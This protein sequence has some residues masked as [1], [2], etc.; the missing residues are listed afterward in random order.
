MHPES[1]RQRKSDWQR[2]SNW[3][4]GV[5]SSSR[6]PQPSW[7][8]DGGTHA[9]AT[10]SN[11]NYLCNV[12]SAHCSAQPWLQSATCSWGQS[13]LAYWQAQAPM[14][15][16]SCAG[17]PS[18]TAAA[19]CAEQQCQVLQFKRFSSTHNGLA[20]RRRCVTAARTTHCN[21]RDLHLS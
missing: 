2:E 17:R 21:G 10:F 18:S 5:G 7:T 15:T 12:M 14:M 19:I 3:P 6:L 13:K 9:A 8:G 1:D 20:Q 16:H 11:Y 4:R